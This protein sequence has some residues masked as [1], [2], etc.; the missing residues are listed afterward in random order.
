MNLY[1]LVFVLIAQGLR[2]AVA[3]SP[4]TSE[5]SSG[6]VKTLLELVRKKKL[7]FRTKNEGINIFKNPKNTNPRKWLFM[8]KVLFSKGQKLGDK[9]VKK[10]QFF[11]LF[12]LILHL[13]KLWA[14]ENILRATRNFG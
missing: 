11:L 7:P 3:R 1:K 4:H 14:C 10:M 9:I 12:F 2:L 5:N 6:Q 8:K 13:Q